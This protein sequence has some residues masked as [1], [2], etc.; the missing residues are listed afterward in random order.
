MADTTMAPHVVIFP[1]PAQGHVNSM[2]KLAELLCLAGIHVTFLVS[3]DIHK[4]LV[5]NSDV[6][7]RFTSYSTFKFETLPSEIYQDNPHTNDLVAFL[8]NSLKV[9][10]KPFLRELLK[11]DHYHEAN[12]PPITCI[13][14]DGIISFAIDL[15]EELGV[16]VI[17]FRTISAC[18]FWAYFCIP[19]LMEAEELPFTDVGCDMDVPI[20]NV[21]GME[22]FLRRRDLPDFCR[23][24]D[25]S[26]TGFTMVLTETQQTPRAHGL[27]LNTFEDLE[28]PILSQIRTHCPNVYTIGPLHA[29]LKARLAAKSSS[30]SLWEEDGNCIKWLDEQ[31]S[32]SVIFVSFG[33]ITV[34]TKNQLLE[35]WHGIVNSSKR[36]LWVMRPEYIIDQDDASKIP[37]ELEKATKERGYMVNWAPQEQV[38]AH[39]A[40]GGFLTHSGWNSTLE[41]IFEG[42]PMICWPF[43]ADQ[44]MNSRFVEEVWKLGIDIKDT[45]DRAIVEKKVRELM[46]VRSEELLKK[47]NTMAKLARDSIG[48]G[49][50]SS[51]NLDR[52]I[53][54]I[55][56]TVTP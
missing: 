30:N 4:R 51:L 46:E 48:E 2:L 55:K 15:A 9:A 39:N 33:S 27:I 19:Q 28:G 31:P 12:R 13:I 49:G 5:R 37:L 25:L 52:L 26:S 50:S 3:I 11:R 18:A 41:S 38:L 42:V 36:F 6:E 7:S 56:A 16:S 1:F 34:L 22:S 40:I 43:F 32:R 21:K 54:H 47:A 29:H 45:C 10:A 53:Q 8:H 17:Y 24:S 23:A 44:Q 35:F 20:K 14:A